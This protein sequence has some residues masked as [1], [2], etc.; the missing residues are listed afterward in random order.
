LTPL[1]RRPLCGLELDQLASEDPIMALAKHTL[2]E[3]S[4]DP[5]TYHLPRA[6]DDA[7]KL[8]RVAL[9]TSRAEGEARILLKLLELRFGPLS[10]A[11]RARV[12]EAT[13]KRLDVWAER[14]LT[15][16]TL[17]EVLAP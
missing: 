1:G 9:A 6:R 10:D 13:L 14:V 4:L 11:T 15:A 16:T 3:L 2:E 8:Y 12:E 5:E 7:E 17:D